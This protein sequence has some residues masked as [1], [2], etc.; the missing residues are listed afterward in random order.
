MG[1]RVAVQVRL[2]DGVGVGVV[3][4][5]TAKMSANYQIASMFWYP[6]RVKGASGA[7]SERVLERHLAASVAASAEVILVMVP[8]WKK[9]PVFDVRSTRVSGTYMQ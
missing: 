6:K 7:G 8:L 4:P 1:N 2:G 9:S 5:F 3:V